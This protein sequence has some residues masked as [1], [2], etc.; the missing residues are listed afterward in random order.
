MELLKRRDYTNFS[1]LL[2]KLEVHMMLEKV[3][4]RIY[5]RAPD[6][7]FTT[8]HDSVITTT[9]YADLVQETMFTTYKEVLGVAPAIERSDLHPDAAF[10]DL[11]DYVQRKIDKNIGEGESPEV[12]NNRQQVERWL[13]TQVTGVDAS[14]V[15][16]FS[17]LADTSPRVNPFEVIEEDK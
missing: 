9:E 13:R 1:V 17:E 8:I 6:A 14:L 12:R 7:W 16:P 2:Q 11:F 3:S 10:H 5:D 15:Y 4:R